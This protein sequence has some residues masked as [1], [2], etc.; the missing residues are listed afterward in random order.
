M[1]ERSI[2]IFNLIKQNHIYFKN[3]TFYKFQCTAAAS[4]QTDFA[5]ERLLLRRIYIVNIE[6]ALTR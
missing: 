1:K 3:Y 6:G 2:T 4:R 5:I